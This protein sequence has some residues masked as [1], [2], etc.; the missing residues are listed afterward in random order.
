MDDYYD[1]SSS[2][3]ANDDREKVLD[4]LI[5]LN[6][7]N[8]RTESDRLQAAVAGASIAS[9]GMAAADDVD[10]Q[11]RLMRNRTTR[12]LRSKSARSLPAKRTELWLNAEADFRQMKGRGTDPGY[13]MNAWGGTVGGAYTFHNNVQA[14]MAVTAMFGDLNIKEPDTM[15]A[16]MDTQYLSTFV[17]VDKGRWSH[18]F[19]AT[20]GLV[21]VDAKRSVNIGGT[22]GSYTTHFDTNG[23]GLGLMYEVNRS[24]VLDREATAILQPVFN[25]AWRHVELDGFTERGSDAA[26]RAG[27]Q[28]MDTLILGAGTRLQ[29]LVESEKLGC[30]PLIELRALLKGYIGDADNHV[31]VS[32]ADRTSNAVIRSD[33]SGA[34]GAELGVNITVPLDRNERYEHVIFVDVNLELRDAYRNENATIGYKLSF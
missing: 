10:R 32:F 29:A 19:I 7:E 11:L 14:G 30:E 33:K 23:Y 5:D 22:Y 24:F 25:I 26:L 27:R 34:I 31:S 1:H 3:H 8:K 18:S 6:A 28:K 12:N 20:V 4:R 13:R 21:D 9:L 2:A 17:R 15:K 16:D